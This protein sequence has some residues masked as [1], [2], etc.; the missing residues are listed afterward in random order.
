MSASSLLRQNCR[1]CCL[2]SLGNK[3]LY[4]GVAGKSL[5]FTETENGGYKYCSFKEANESS[6]FPPEEWSKRRVCTAIACSVRLKQVQLQQL[7]RAAA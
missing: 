3:V 4:L 2:S 5:S 1:L 7:Q 6:N